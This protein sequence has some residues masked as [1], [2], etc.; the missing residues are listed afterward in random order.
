MED[1][2]GFWGYPHPDTIDEY[3]KMYPQANFVDL[4]VDYGVCEKNILPKAYCK[5]IKNLVD[6]A[7]HF[8][9]KVILAAVGKEKC[10]SGFFCA[11][12]LKDFG[13]KVVETKF[14]SPQIPSSIRIST[15][16]L[17]LRQKIETITASIIS[18]IEADFVQCEPKFGFW[19]VPP[20]DLSILELFP[21]ET[22][23]F[24]WSRCV[25]AKTPADIELE[26]Y[27]PENLPTVFYSQAF[28]AKMQLAK[29]LADKHN[30]LFLDIDDYAS[31]SVKAK[32]EAFLRLR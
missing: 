21:N 17:P 11:Q 24:G 6:N 13:F 9:P 22:H 7:F 30:G 23:V 8:K 18:P 15:S 20:N 14:E 31:N 27:V 5:I 29:H 12:I 19:G 16:N 4:D 28:C 3:K 32:I 10:D 25:E 1:I 2:I 26:M